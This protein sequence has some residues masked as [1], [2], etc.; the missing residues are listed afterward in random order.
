MESPKSSSPS[1]TSYKRFGT[2]DLPEESTQ[3]ESH[4]GLDE[5]LEAAES[6]SEAAKPHLRGDEGQERF[7][8]ISVDRVS[9]PADN[10][11][12]DKRS[13]LSEVARIVRGKAN[14]AKQNVSRLARQPRDLPPRVA[15]AS[16]SAKARD[17]SP[18]KAKKSLK[19]T[20]DTSLELI[21]TKLEAAQKR[22]NRAIRVMIDMLIESGVFTEEEFRTRL[23]VPRSRNR[24]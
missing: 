19:E 24:R 9:P 11:K 6:P 18:P 17:R 4:Y 22:Q 15:S 5:E 8:S 16:T 23:G 12:K 20:S 14:S 13:N 21:T 1:N 3:A 10:G 2:I 7:G